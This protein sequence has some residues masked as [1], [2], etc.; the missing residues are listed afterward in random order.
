M[1][2]VGTKQHRIIAIITSG[3]IGLNIRRHHPETVA[4]IGGAPNN[5][6]LSSLG[7]IKRVLGNDKSAAKC[8]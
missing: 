4:S 2:I 8:T 5:L 7:K 6:G 1:N 3:I